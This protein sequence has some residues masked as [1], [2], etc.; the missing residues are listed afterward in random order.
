MDDLSFSV[1]FEENELFSFFYD[2]EA[3]QDQSPQQLQPY[4]GKTETIIFKD[5]NAPNYEFA[6]QPVVEDFGLAQEQ[7]PALFPLLDQLKEEP[8]DMVEELSSPSEFEP[9]EKAVKS[10]GRGRRATTTTTTKKEKKPKAPKAAKR[11]ATER[12]NS[13]RPAKKQKIEKTSFI[14]SLKGMTSG[15]LE[16]M[17]ETQALTPKEQS[18][19]KKYTRMIKNRESAQL[20]R[21]RRK[22]YQD[23]LEKALSVESARN[24]EL[25][26][27]IIELEVENKVLQREFLEFK[28]LIENSNLG[29]AFSSFADN[30]AFK[31]MTK[32][33]A[34]GDSQAQATFAMY[35]LIVLHAFGQQFASS[36]EAMTSVSNALGA[37]IEARA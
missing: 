25:K 7:M 4:D 13:K 11:V 17:A 23:T 16:Q 14:G 24:A 19:L 28:T 26:Q 29:K 30:N 21:E 31:L 1:P 6:A 15:E 18:D 10:K 36:A 32:T 2:G 34:A 27:Q 8:V 9:M 5:P 33:A 35:L 22:I 3:E 12:K 37:P 20:S